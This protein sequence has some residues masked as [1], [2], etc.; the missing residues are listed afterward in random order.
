MGLVAEAGLRRQA[1]REPEP[2]P[3]L[4]PCVL[5]ALKPLAKSKCPS[6]GKEAREDR[7]RSRLAMNA[8]PLE[9]QARRLGGLVTCLDA[10][11]TSAGPTSAGPTSAAASSSSS[12]QLKSSLAS[13]QRTTF[14]Q[15]GPEVGLREECLLE[16]FEYQAEP[17]LLKRKHSLVPLLNLKIRHQEENPLLRGRDKD[18]RALSCRPGRWKRPGKSLGHYD[19]RSRR[20]FG[21]SDG[22]STMLLRRG[23]V[24][25]KTYTIVSIIGVGFAGRVYVPANR[26]RHLR[27]RA[28]VPEYA[29]ACPD[30][31]LDLSKLEDVFDKDPHRKKLVVAGNRDQLMDLILDRLYFRYSFSSPGD[32]SLKKTTTFEHL[33]DWG[34]CRVSDKSIMMT[35]ELLFDRSL[36]LPVTVDREKQRRDR[37]NDR[38]RERADRRM[39]WLTTPKRYRGC[40]S[41]YAAKVSGHMAVLRFFHSSERALSVVVTA[42]PKLRE[43]KV[44]LTYQDLARQLGYCCST[45]VLDDDQEETRALLRRRVPECARFVGD[46]ELDRDDAREEANA[47]KNPCPQRKQRSPLRVG[48]PDNFKLGTRLVNHHS[49]AR[50]L[51]PVAAENPHPVRGGK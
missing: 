11:P 41:V 25:S 36:R 35:P 29:A 7:L 15:L 45:A 6:K 10:G 8:V 49:E 4:L 18:W 39:K 5:P 14:W 37:E 33:E 20:I 42:F 1:R 21:L 46:D 47:K 12:P 32:G 31:V 17:K 26:S 50:G 34:P 13:V 22:A 28:Y 30:L 43:F 24:I 27:V 9:S 40:V 16:L 51:V 19:A 2:L 23:L 48:A 38:D 3:S 44:R